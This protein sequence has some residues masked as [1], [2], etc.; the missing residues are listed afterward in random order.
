MHTLTINFYTIG[1]PGDYCRVLRR[2]AQRGQRGHRVFE[3][4]PPAL[5]PRTG[6]GDAIVLLHEDRASLADLIHGVRPYLVT[7]GVPRLAEGELDRF[8]AVWAAPD[9]ATFRFHAARLIERLELERRLLPAGDFRPSPP[10]PFPAPVRKGARAIRGLARPA[11]RD[12][13]EAEAAVLLE[14]VPCALLVADADGHVVAVNGL[15]EALFGKVAAADAEP[16]LYHARGDRRCPLALARREELGELY[17]EATTGEGPQGQESGE[18]WVD[19]RHRPLAGARGGATLGTI[20]AFREV[21]GEGR[22]HDD[23]ARDIY[24]DALTGLRNRRHFYETTDPGAGAGLIF[25]DLDRFKD[26]NDIY[27]HKVGDECL[28][29]AGRILRGVDERFARLGGDEFA[30]CEP[31]ATLEALERK[32][33]VIGE[34]LRGSMYR[35]FPS[36][37]PSIGIACAQEGAEETL[38]DLVFRAD[39]AMYANKRERA[40]LASAE[41]LFHS[42]VREGDRR[43]VA[44]IA[45]LVERQRARVTPYT[46]YVPGMEDTPYSRCRAGAS[47]RRLVR[48]R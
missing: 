32:A 12:L 48:P 18:A 40:R 37:V 45:R 21:A 28:A 11:S 44:A 25:I 38:D 47:R 33:R 42:L 7:R 20:V 27:G 35:R 23:M 4:L 15:F 17:P 19:I 24:V 8:E 9:A 2:L 16:A 43:N 10:E 26:V 31:G 39:A 14:S 29:L 22:R 46:V 36:V 13:L 5:C 30:L 3:T 34:R 1:L 41:R 6:H